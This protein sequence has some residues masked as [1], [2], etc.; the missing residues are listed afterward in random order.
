[1][2]FSVSVF[3]AAQRDAQYLRVL[4]A[5]LS[6][7]LNKPITLQLPPSNQGRVTTQETISASVGTNFYVALD[8][9]GVAPDKDVPLDFAG[10][11]GEFRD[12]K[13]NPR[14]G[15]YR[16]QS[17][18]DFFPL[19]NGQGTGTYTVKATLPD[20]TLTAQTQISFDAP[21]PLTESLAITASPTE[22]LATWQSPTR[23]QSYLAFVYDRTNKAVV[24]ATE[25]KGNASTLEVT[26]GL[27]L[28]VGVGYD[29]T[30]VT[31]D[32]DD[33]PS[34]TRAYP[35]TLPERFNASLINRTLIVGKP[36]IEI[37]NALGGPEI[38]RLNVRAA[39]NAKVTANA[40]I[41]N[42][43]SGL[44]RY[45]IELPTGDASVRLLSPSSGRA[46]AGE[47]VP[48]DLQADCGPGESERTVAVTVKSNDEDEPTKTLEV[49]VECL[50]RITTQL[51]W[52]N[53]T[54]LNPVS[55]IAWKP[56]GSRA[57]LLGQSGFR[58]LEVATGRIVG[59]QNFFP[60]QS[61]D[62]VLWNA[63][64]SRFALLEIGRTTIY[65]AETLEVVRTFNAG[66]AAGWSPDGTKIV[67]SSS[68]GTGQVWRISDGASVLTL[69][70]WN[71]GA[72]AI[73]WNADGSRIAASG[74]SSGFA[75]RDG[76]TVW[77]STTGEVVRRIDLLNNAFGVAW[78]ADGTQVA[79]VVANQARRWNVATGAEAAATT[80][81]TGSYPYY[82]TLVAWSNNKFFV[83]S[84][85]GA[86]AVWN[87]QATTPLYTVATGTFQQAAFNE[88]TNRILAPKDGQV[89]VHSGVNGNLI[90]SVP[91]RSGRWS[92][93][94]WRPAGDRFAVLR[95]NSLEVYDAAGALI[96]DWVITDL[97]SSLTKLSWSRNGNKIAVSGNKLWIYDANT[98]QLLID[99]TFPST[100]ED[101]LWNTDDTFIA[102]VS[103]RL[104]V[105]QANTL[106]TQW[107]TTSSS[108]VTV[109][110][111]GTRLLV[112]SG[113]F[114][115][116]LSLR[117][118]NSGVEIKTFDTS[119]IPAALTPTWSPMAQ[120]FATLGG[121]AGGIVTVWNLEPDSRVML[122]PISTQN[123]V[124]DHTGRRVLA[125]LGVPSSSA[126]TPVV[127]SAA[128]AAEL[129]R[130]P[131]INVPTF[132][133]PQVAWNPNGSSLLVNIGGTELHLMNLVYTP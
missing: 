33:T 108:R 35:G 101:A 31:F 121:V 25:G 109:D 84:Q 102:V 93:M 56:D 27:N 14:R 107:Q 125:V 2:N 78:S 97:S 91:V 7:A 65:N 133:A 41:R 68:D 29:F 105:V 130:L 20:G 113:M 129:E 75:S 52:K 99:K 23:T 131:I 63:D 115:V 62:A 119:G 90:A 98:G 37:T 95:D 28:T 96:R 64:G 24:W 67:L 72:N 132:T 106:V 89:N 51:A 120:R 49:L 124:W 3:A 59:G 39:P 127:Y 86:L 55:K 111:A 8:K 6:K 45:S 18:W 110:P 88:A 58:V 53:L 79:S 118:F 80:I 85:Y 42:L 13:G 117:Q 71:Y 114:P 10:P 74:S 21:L 61:L 83:R 5:Q 116:S 32:F 44:L 94:A 66:R 54:G 11:S 87:P 40:K 100:V 92:A 12:A 123:Y 38:A 34:R 46:R 77:N 47:D 69:N 16:A 1:M 43:S 112:S 70:D 60:G 126:Y 122:S 15:V 81:S 19:L 48:L 73:V 30:L 82:E 26:Q 17:N 36:E 103:N 128:S 57:L 104:D 22:L 76:V 9:N 4:E 50:R